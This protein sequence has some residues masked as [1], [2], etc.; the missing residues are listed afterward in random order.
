MIYITEILFIRV[1]NSLTGISQA[2]HWVD[3]FLH[4]LL[5]LPC[6]HHCKYS[7]IQIYW[8][9]TNEPLSKH[10]FLCNLFVAMRQWIFCQEPY[11]QMVHLLDLLRIR[12]LCFCLSSCIP[13]LAH[14]ISGCTSVRD[15]IAVLRLKCTTQVFQFT[16]TALVHLYHY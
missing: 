13:Y 8:H 7:F 15:N 9:T 16:F 4:H 6:L 2:T 1:P 14:L 10:I 11:H 5:D 12:K 3:L